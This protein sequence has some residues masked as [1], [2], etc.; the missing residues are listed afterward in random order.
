MKVHHLNCGTMHLPGS[1]LV[2]HTLLIEAANGLVLVD[3]GFGTADIA[4]P[5]GRLGFSRRMNHPALDPAETAVQQVQRLGFDTADVRHI[6]ATHL[7]ADHIGGLSDFP[8][9]VV[10]TTAAEALGAIHN[11]TRSER[12]RFRPI[13]WAHQPTIVEHSFGGESW[14]GF[15]AATELTEIAPGIVLIFLP[16]HTRGHAAVAVDAGHRWVLHCGDAF[17]HRGT[18]DGRTRVPTLM[19]GFEKLIAFDRNQVRNNHA[20]LSELYRRNEPDL[21]MVCAHDPVMLEHAQSTA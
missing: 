12:T 17:L 19:A 8:T 21:L 13:A 2:C 16:G 1:D 20:R 18:V 14:R 3:S 4:D 6:I 9:A 15:A 10:H 5:V 7:D 11:P